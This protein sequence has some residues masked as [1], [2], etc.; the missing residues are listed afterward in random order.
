[1]AVVNLTGG[2]SA[3]PFDGLNKLYRIKNRIDF[4]QNNVSASDVVHTATVKANTHVKQV[5]VKLITPEG[6]TATCTIGDSGDADGLIASA[7]LNAAAGTITHNTIT[8]A[9]ANGRIYTSETDILLIPAHNLSN[10]V[11]DIMVVCQDL[12]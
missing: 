9:Y 3:I 5:Y 6:S 7:N 12:N 1:M 4:S 11:V 10:A 2:Q 8:D